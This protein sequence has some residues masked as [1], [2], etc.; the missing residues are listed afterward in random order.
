MREKFRLRGPLA[1]FAALLVLTVQPSFSQN[2]GPGEDWNLR[3]DQDG[4][5]VYTRDVEGSN[6]DAFRGEVDL[7]ATLDEVLAFLKDVPNHRE[8]MQNLTKS[9]Q[10]GEINPEGYHSYGRV[11]APWPV[12]DRDW[13]VRWEI[14]DDAEETAV[15]VTFKKDD[16][17]RPPVDDAVRTG[18]FEGFW[19]LVPQDNG[20]TRVIY[21]VSHADPG[22]LIP[23]WIVNAF[24]VNQPYGTLSAMRDRLRDE[25][26]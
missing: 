11:K 2:E 26:H 10:I 5:Q 7:E 3:K 15:K 4:I 8:W 23:A 18:A 20:T 24:V 22:G 1:V 9:E 25:V 12:R 6:F 16:G 13:V 21:E 17:V 14:L 19:R